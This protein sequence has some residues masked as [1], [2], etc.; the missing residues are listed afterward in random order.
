MALPPRPVEGTLGLEPKSPPFRTLS[1]TG[2]APLRTHA[3]VHRQIRV[4]ATHYAVKAKD[5]NGSAGAGRTHP[6]GSCCGRARAATK[7]APLTMDTSTDTDAVWIERLTTSCAATCP[8]RSTRCPSQ[9][10]QRRGLRCRGWRTSGL[11]VTAAVLLANSAARPTRRKQPAG[12]GAGRL[13]RAARTAEG[14]GGRL[15]HRRCRDR[16]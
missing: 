7:A 11:S 10:T 2:A 5:S 3:S 4:S 12:C 6:P 14:T 13:L 16:R 15:R 9:F 8:N 1:A